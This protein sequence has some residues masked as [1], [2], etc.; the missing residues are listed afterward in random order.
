MGMFVHLHI[1]IR[2]K[3]MNYSKLLD[4][5]LDFGEAMMSAGGEIS[6]TEDSINRMGKAY[7]ASNR[8]QR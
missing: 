3:N 7:G 1:F 8:K 4:L 6:R 2:W 5:F